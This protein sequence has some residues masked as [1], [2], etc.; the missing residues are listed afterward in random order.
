[1]IKWKK[2]S[3]NFVDSKNTEQ[4]FD[5]K[6]TYAESF[7][8]PA[9]ITET[10]TSHTRTIQNF[11]LVWLD[12]N[13]NEVND[14]DCI[15]TITKLR[16]VVNAVKTFTDVNECIKFITNIEYENIFI[17]CSGSLG[18]STVPII[19]DMAQINSIYIFCNNKVRHEKWAKDWFKVKGVFTDIES[20]C[21]ALKQTAQECDQNTISISFIKKNDKIS[22]EN[23]DQLDQAFMYTQTLK[24]IIFTTNF[25]QKHIDKFL[26]CCRELIAGNTI[27]LKNIEKIEKKYY[28]YKPIWWYIYQSF[29]YSV[30]NRALCTMEMDLIIKMG[31]FIRDLHRHIDQLHSEQYG[32]DHQLDS[33]TVFRGQGLSQTNFDQLM[34]TKGG[35]LSFNNFLSTSKNRDVSLAFARR[36]MET[37]SLVGILFIMKIDPSISSTPFANI[38]DVI[39]YQTEEEILFSMHSVF[40]IGKIQ[41]LHTNNRLWQVELTLTDDN[42]PQ[43][44]ALTDRLREEMQDSTGWFRLGKLMVTLAEYKKAENFYE[45]LLTQETN[46]RKRAP[47]YYQL[48]L[49]KSCQGKYADAITFYE[50]SITLYQKILPLQHSDGTARK[51]SAD[52]LYEKVPQMQHESLDFIHYHISACYNDMAI[53]YVKMKEYS[54][55]LPYYE[56]ILEIRQRT[57]PSNHLDLIASYDSIG[58]VHQHL[59]NY[60]QAIF[61]LEKAFEITQAVLPSNHPN[62]ASSCN[63]IAGMYSKLGQYSEALSYYEKV[64][65][66]QQKSLPENHL[67]AATCYSNIGLM[68]DN[69]GDY[70]KALSSH[71]KALEIREK[72]F[73]SN[74]SDLA[75]SYSNIGLVYDNMGDYKKALQYYKKDLEISKKILPPDHPDLAISYNNI[76][77]VYDNIGEYSK[78]LLSHKTALEIYQQTLHPNHP[79]L[80]TSHK[81]I[82]L[83]HEN[84]ASYSKALLSHEKALEIREKV[85]SPNHPDLA[86]SY[87]NIGLVYGKMGD[88]TKAVSFYERAVDI[89]QSSFSVEH[90]CLQLWKNNLETT[91][92]KL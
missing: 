28:Q 40:R 48:G 20:I 60:P 66:I 77:L 43:L 71:M 87:N 4:S 24:E 79:H 2:K 12:S 1:M 33:F 6:P 47:I 58:L 75:T 14:D 8:G 9:S 72:I 34:E 42:D 18:Q 26:T 44:Y 38:R 92:K 53:A 10:S 23:L 50:N 39:A 76:G 3:A 35:L 25:E 30:L 80:A 19:H 51:N 29:L 84:M 7:S 69:I 88:Y 11:R 22:N 62:L 49:T 64:L 17:I 36:T 74:L 41:Q 85:L 73:P 52:L 81:N 89:G 59:G 57:L 27:E 83:V 78:A 82:G 61:Y 70:S 67:D 13:I 90:P 37:S 65:E 45:I 68:Y 91:K 46:D 56:K 21:D 15:N 63:S 55:A 86:T 54:K 16:Q 31:F 5:S 32:K